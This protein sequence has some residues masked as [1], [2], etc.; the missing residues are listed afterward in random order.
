MTGSVFVRD[1][2]GQPLMPISARYARVLVQR[3]QA[4]FL[5]HYAFRILQLSH[6]ITA[7]RVRP[8]TLG[9]ALNVAS[10]DL[11]LV[12]NQRVT[13][14]PVLH[15]VVDLQLPPR[16]LTMRKAV[17]PRV[18]QARR[19]VNVLAATIAVLTTLVP[20][21]HVRVLPFKR[22]QAIVDWN[23]ASIALRDAERLQQRLDTPGY[24]SSTNHRPTYLPT[25]M[26]DDL[27]VELAAH[28]TPHFIA[29]PQHA[30][31]PRWPSS[32][33]WPQRRLPHRIQSFAAY[34]TWPSRKENIALYKGNWGDQ[35]I[36]GLRGV[37]PTA[38]HLD[39]S[40]PVAVNE[41]G[42][43]WR[44]TTASDVEPVRGVG[45]DQIV[46]VPPMRQ[47]ASQ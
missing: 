16:A 4:Q 19:R 14:V 31:L 22:E 20:I 30:P 40:V 12:V 36:L 1:A 15:V 24:W 17:P 46:F 23:L 25:S 38:R 3:G 47:F 37:G 8:V 5:P 29:R 13:L 9:I 41:Y 32:T 26:V 35:E 18:T 43:D 28:G 34:F 11:V 39:L 2:L 44:W 21:S 45:Q 42:V 7:P 27:V 33:Q 6:V 10:A